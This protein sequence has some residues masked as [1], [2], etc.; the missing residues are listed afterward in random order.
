MSSSYDSSRSRRRGPWGHWVPLVLTVAVATAGVA[1]WAWSQRSNEEEEEEEH[2]AGD[3]DYENADYGDNPAY[4]ASGPTNYGTAAD[5][6]SSARAA[7][8]TT[9]GVTEAREEAN[10]NAGWGM[11]GALRRTP[12]PQQFLTNAGKTLAA[13]AGA[14]GA[15]MG[16]ALAA[17]R[18]E[19]KTA[20]ADHETWSQEAESRRENPRDNLKDAEKDAPRETP[21]ETPRDNPRENLKTTTS[22]EPPKVTPREAGKRRK[23]VAV[24]VSADTNI[25]D[26]DE[27]GFHEHAVGCHLPQTNT[28]SS[29]NVP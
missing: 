17:I 11:S 25:D 2:T 22:D 20:Y 15:A 23:T 4:G 13:G 7:G 9:Y 27:D 26:F 3:L 12:S 29:V 18:E 1:V 24:V 10:L 6:S 16:S 28:S 14:V 8:G 5:P 19:D 21:A